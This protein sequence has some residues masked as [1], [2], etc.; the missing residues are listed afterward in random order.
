MKRHHFFLENE[1]R[2]NKYSFISSMSLLTSNFYNATGFGITV[3]LCSRANITQMVATP[4]GNALYGTMGSFAGD[5]SNIVTFGLVFY[6]YNQFIW[7]S[8]RQALGVRIFFSSY[9]LDNV[10]IN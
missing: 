4:I 9:I 3:A 1:I 8:V 10:K 7:P 5:V 6:V 2:L